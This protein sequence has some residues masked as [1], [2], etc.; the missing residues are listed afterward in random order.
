[1]STLRLP[2][3]AYSVTSQGLVSACNFLL[4]LALL[5]F[6]EAKHYV[7]FLLFLNIVQLLTGLQNALFISPV[8]VLIPRMA[9]DD[10]ARVEKFAYRLAMAIALVGVPFVA[11]FLTEPPRDHSTAL[12][13]IAATFIGT[14]LLMQREIARNAC[15]V[16]SDLVE[17]VKFD[18]IYF[19]LAMALAG[20]AVYLHQLSFVWAVI[21]FALPA[22]LTRLSRPRWP[23]SRCVA[24]EKAVKAFDLAF[25]SEVTQVVRWAL[26]GVVITW[27]FSNGYWFILEHTQPTETVANMGAARLLF[28]PVGLLV[29]GW[30]MQLRPLSVSMAH[31]GRLAELRKKVMRH[32][33]AGAV[34]VGLVTAVGYLLLKYAPQVLPRSMRVAGVVDYVFVWGAYFAVFWFRSGISTL[35]QAK[36]K[37]FRTVFFAN[38]IVCAVFYALF[39]GSLN[40]V[41]PPISLATL[42]VAELLMIYLLN[43]RIND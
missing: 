28:A 5:Y 24:P 23:A 31:D 34:C 8:G 42:I 11:I 29:Q 12:G 17:L 35:L 40:Y 14:I 16:R 30:L 27:L 4:C 37:G 2:R 22:C 43:R 38:V 32:S 1:M 18:A 7:A 6:A 15:L 33:A 36:A 25:R 39:A 13:V 41:Q 26:P 19:A 21:A 3:A 9:P 10:V 20:S